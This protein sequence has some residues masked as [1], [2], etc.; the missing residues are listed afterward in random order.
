MM[1]IVPHAVVLQRVPTYILIV[2]VNAVLIA[3]G[4]YF[5]L[6]LS[7]ALGDAHRKMHL[8][9]WQLRQLIPREARAAREAGRMAG[10]GVT[11]GSR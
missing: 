10:G 3:L 4:A 7:G 6:T 9:A 1:C 8:Q 11:G 5:G 2:A